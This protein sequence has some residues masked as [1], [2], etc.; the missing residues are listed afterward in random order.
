LETPGVNAFNIVFLP[1]TQVYSALHYEIFL[2]QTAWIQASAES[3]KIKMVLHEGDIVDGNTAA[4]WANA[5]SA[6]SHLADVP[7]LL[8]LGNHDFDDGTPARNEVT[9]YN[10]NFGQS[11]YTAKAWWNGDFYEASHSENAYHI[12]TV[13][14]ND[15]LFISLEFGPRDEVLTW[16]D[17]IIAANPTATVIIVTHSYM[18]QDGTRV[19]TGDDF[20]PKTYLG[21]ANDGE[22]MWTELVKK[23]DNI[24]IIGSGHHFGTPYAAQRTDTGDEGN[25]VNQMFIN[26]QNDTNGGN[27]W[28]RM[29]TIDPVANTVRVQTI[30]PYLLSRKTDADNL[31]TWTYKAA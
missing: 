16:A 9:T 15:Y 8:A 29:L 18:Y 23:Y 19:G 5:V 1:D 10:T 25:I 7:H 30:S 20:N 4:Q 22:E 12:L 2:A 31:F 6:I 21:D 28:L 14:G 27:G 17:G 13:D 26:H 11:Y 3:L 24:A